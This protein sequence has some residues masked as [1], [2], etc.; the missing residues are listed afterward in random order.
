VYYKQLL[1]EVFA[2]SKIVK[3]K[4]KVSAIIQASVEVSVIIHILIIQDI[5]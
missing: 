1:D 2:I 3:D 4:V 5:H